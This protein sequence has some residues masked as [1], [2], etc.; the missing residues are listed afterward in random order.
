MAYIIGPGGMGE[1]GEFKL[2]FECPPD[3]FHTTMIDPVT[4]VHAC[5]PFLNWYGFDCKGNFRDGS[6]HNT[7]GFGADGIHKITG[8]RF[9]TRGRDWRR[10]D[11]LGRL[12]DG[13]RFDEDGFGADFY[14]RFGVSRGGTHR[15]GSIAKGPS[16]DPV[17]GRNYRGFNKF[18]QYVAKWSYDICYHDERGFGFHGIHRATHRL[19]DPEGRNFNGLTVREE[20]AIS[21]RAPLLLMRQREMAKLIAEET[22]K[23]A[24]TA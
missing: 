15:D 14:D 7:L 18:G 13:K 12:P 21:R 19:Y 16:F 2:M 6:R 20:D 10:F 11:A 5:K 24:A 3:N 22:A 8:T 23:Q 9:D 4:R 17:T 1:D